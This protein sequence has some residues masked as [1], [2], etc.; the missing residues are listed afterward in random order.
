MT[1][2]DQRPN[3]PFTF[4]IELTLEASSKQEASAL[5]TERLKLSG[6]REYRIVHVQS[7]ASDPI[8]SSGI[9]PEPVSPEPRTIDEL[10]NQIMK[11]QTLVRL[12][13]VKDRGVRLSLP[14]RIVHFDIE[15]EQIMA[16]H[17][18]EKAVYTFKLNEIEDF[19]VSQ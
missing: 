12:N 4:Q 16:Y 13:I 7:D 18:D 10:I 11:D 2:A 8:H 1:P 9:S 17:V 19:Q 14:C 3:R 5:L 6:V 15:M